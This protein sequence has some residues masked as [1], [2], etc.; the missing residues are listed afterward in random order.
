MSSKY[1]HKE[2]R[3]FTTRYNRLVY[4]LKNEVWVSKAFDPT[5]TEEKDLP[6]YGKYIGL[7]DTGATATGITPRIVKELGLKPSGVVNVSGVH[8]SKLVPTYYIN[9]LLPNNVGIYGIPATE[10]ENI[11]TADVLIGMDIIIYGDFAISNFDNKTVFSFRTPSIETIDFANE[12]R[13]ITSKPDPQ[14]SASARQERNR[15][16][17]EKRKKKGN[18]QA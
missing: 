4:E 10:I 2:A 17:R 13:Q 16:K 8:G 18:S 1:L 6:E 5:I 3:A 14:T 11:G 9:V 15:R 12:I 7:W